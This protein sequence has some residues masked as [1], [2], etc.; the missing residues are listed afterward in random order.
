MEVQK[1]LERVRINLAQTSKGLVQFDLTAEAE[2]PER[3]EALLSAAI[4]KAR[5]T[6]AAKGLKEVHE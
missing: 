6:I 5:G 1:I 4:D 2:T 3:V